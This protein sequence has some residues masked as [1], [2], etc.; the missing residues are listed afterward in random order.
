MELQLS[1]TA[2]EFLSL[3]IDGLGKSKR[4]ASIVVA[5]RSDSGYAVSVSV[6][7]GVR[8]VAYRS[9]LAGAG[10][11]P[12]WTFEFSGNRIV[13]SSEWSAQFE[14]PPMVFRFDLKQVDSTV[15]GL[16]R[17]DN[18]LATPVLMHFPCQ[19]SM[20]LTSSVSDLGLTYESSR[21]QET[22]MLS[23]P[24]ATFEHRRVV[25]T[26]E[27]TALYPDVPGIAGDARFDPFRRD[28]LNTLQLNPSLQALANNTAS[29]TC[30]FCYYEYADIAALSPPLAEG[31]TA[32]DLVRQTLDRMLAGGFAY[33]ISEV[34]ARPTVTSDFYPSMLIAAANCV[35]GGGNDAWLAANYEG[36]RGW[37]ESMLATD[38]NG[39]GLIKTCVSGDSG[40]WANG[41]P[42]I[43]PSNWWDTIG[44]GY[45]DAYANALAYRAL[46]NMAMMAKRMGKYND[47]ERYLAAAAKL[48]GAYYT[49]FYNPATGVLGGWRSTDGHL[50]DYYFLWV[51]GTAI[52]YG[53]VEKPQADSIMDK[54]MA[55]MK[56]VG[57][58]NFKLGLP[59]NL[60]TVALPDCVD[61]R[62]DGR[63]GCGVRPDN[64]DGFQNYENGG[65]TGAFAF[66]TLAALYDLGRKAEADK[67]LFAM[68]DEYSQNGFQQW[69]TAG[70][71]TDWR[72]WDGTPKG[73]EGYL[74]DDYYTLLAVPLRQTETRWQ[75]GSRPQTM[76]GDTGEVALHRET[77]SIR[78]E[79]DGRQPRLIALSVDS[80]RRGDFRA[81]PLVDPGG[82]PLQYTVSES[83]GWIRYALVSDPEHPVW[84]L[85]CDDDTLRMRSLF[86]LKGKPRD[87]TLKFNPNVTHA[88]LLGHATPAGD[89]SLPAVLHLP[90]MGSLRIYA[91]GNGS[92]ALHYDARRSGTAFV[93]V[94]FPAATSEHKILEY[95]L[96]TAAI[97]PAVPGMAADDHQFD[98]FRRDW[99]NIF[100]QQA[101]W[102]VLANNA[103]S[104][105][106]AFTVYEYADIARYTPELVK[107]LTALDLVR[108]TLDRYLAGFIAD[109]MPGYQQFDEPS[110]SFSHPD[111]FLDTYPSLLIAAYDYVDGNGDERWLQQNYKGLR[112][113]AELMTTP[114][115]DD[116]PLLEYRLSG[117]TG[118]WPAKYGSA[119]AANWWDTIGFGHQDAYS[120][121]LGY[122]AL[123]SMAALA[124][125]MGDTADARRY[126]KRAREIH[127][128]YA[129]A[130]LDP[131]TGVVAGWRSSD[132]Q[133]HDYYF[134][135]VNGIAVRYGLIGG[136]QAR[137]VMDRIL[138]KMKSV[139]YTN[140]SLGLPGNLVPIRRDDYLNSDPGAGGSKR[141]DGSDGFQNYENGGATACFSY[142]T[143]AALYHLGEKEQGDKILM[144]MLDSFSRQGFS[145]RAPDGQSYDWKDWKG[146]AHGY[147]GFLVDNYYAL[148]A[149]L[150]R[151]GVM[152]KMP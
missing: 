87:L 92:A 17:Q 146:G 16:F 5:N 110:D 147:E 32:L 124:D 128:A 98:G 18:L 109:G 13:L 75:S 59:G 140:F 39:N 19:G 12:T 108:E 88:T 6:H 99:L 97:F 7:G 34:P 126:R 105:A 145:G 11:L 28:W 142:F 29:D 149:V 3:N 45:E 120:N 80:L 21:P 111:T 133:L 79:F 68:L 69:D 71:S 118:S 85:S 30:A 47:S 53:L 64:S 94:T 73:Y 90:G 66:F 46:P 112:K 67:I 96:Q 40:I 8:R 23:L 31:L 114:N 106:C 65:A 102:H 150:D 78:V 121:A 44:F 43:R 144:P 35:R 57:C 95:T 137:Q 24:G 132:G 55:K 129:Q 148:L 93:A 116:S 76:A 26:L 70:Q 127:D 38:D 103:A 15:L 60:I 107:G 72:R 2:P 101:E 74:V 89:I 141:E 10:S 152:E 61:K 48:R 125:R 100:Q 36:I 49:C 122:R 54:L 1:A 63:F 81:N 62:G 52:H 143:V 83:G 82:A 113:W 9:T 20:R 136:E 42:K 56:E 22:A 27:V 134:T 51:N 123:R 41:D 130:F 84:E 104:D 115:A 37:A 25:Y 131:G 4:G 117:N 91:K 14:P 119:N 77:T 151:A 135:F 58:D 86:S 50:H 33:G 139:G 138:A